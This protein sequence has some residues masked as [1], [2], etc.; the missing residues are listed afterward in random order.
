MK[1]AQ[2]GGREVER[3]FLYCHLIMFFAV[4]YTLLLLVFSFLGNRKHMIPETNYSIKEPT[5]VLKLL[6]LL[7]HGQSVVSCGLIPCYVMFADH[8]DP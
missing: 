7:L 6:R 2:V 5:V 8:K 3:G 4:F 1:G